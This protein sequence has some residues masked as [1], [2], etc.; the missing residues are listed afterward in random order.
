MS[1]FISFHEIFF[2]VARSQPAKP[3]QQ[4]NLTRNSHSG[5]FKVMYFGITEKP[6]TD[7]ISPY[8]NAGLISKVS[9]KIA[10]ENA[11]NCRSRQP[12][13]PTVVWRPIPGEPPRIFAWVLYRQKLESLAYIFCRWQYGSIFIQIFIVGPLSS[14]IPHPPLPFSRPI[15]QSKI[16]YS[17]YLPT[18]GG[19]LSRPIDTARLY[20]V[21][22][23]VTNTELPS[24]EFK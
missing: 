9:E 6:T 2:E 7:C 22:A 12:H 3:A 5:S 8:N 10:S 19:R 17:F 1:I 4:Q 16:W 18:N 21:V 20:I 15:I 23:F 14:T 13:S 24:V 11:Q